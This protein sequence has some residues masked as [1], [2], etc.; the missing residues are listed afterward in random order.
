MVI[1]CV[2][3]LIYRKSMALGEPDLLLCLNVNLER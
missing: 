2:E 3:T 1:G